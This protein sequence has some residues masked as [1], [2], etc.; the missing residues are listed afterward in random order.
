MISRQ[1]AVAQLRQNRSLFE[2]KARTIW[3]ARLLEETRP[4]AEKAPRA[5]R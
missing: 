5:A 4:R 1:P 2:I 3:L